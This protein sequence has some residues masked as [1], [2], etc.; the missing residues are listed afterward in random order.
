VGAAPE[1]TPVLATV[2]F[3]AVLQFPDVVETRVAMVYFAPNWMDIP[4]K[5]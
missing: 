3:A 4:A 5:K 2:Q 1:T